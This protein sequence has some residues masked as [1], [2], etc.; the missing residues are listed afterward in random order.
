MKKNSGI[1]L[2]EKK[3]TVFPRKPGFWKAEVTKSHES[4]SQ[5]LVREI[6]LDSRFLKAAKVKN[7]AQKFGHQ[8]TQF[9]T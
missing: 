5:E 1:G 7:C 3:T 4:W 6:A 2:H 9:F 8:K